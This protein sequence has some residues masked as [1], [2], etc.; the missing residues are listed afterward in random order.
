MLQCPLRCQTHKHAA[1][2]HMANA[3]ILTLRL[4]QIE[5]LQRWET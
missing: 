3:G 2:R 1:V 4:E 5:P